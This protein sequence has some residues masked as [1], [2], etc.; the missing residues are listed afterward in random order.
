MF[1]QGLL[2]VHDSYCSLFPGKIFFKRKLLFLKKKIRERHWVRKEKTTVNATSSELVRGAR[3]AGSKTQVVQAAQE[4]GGGW[5]GIPGSLSEQGR[6]GLPCCHTRLLLMRA[7]PHA[8]VLG[9]ITFS[10]FDKL[11]LL[12]CYREGRSCFVFVFLKM[13]I[14]AKEIRLRQKGCLQIC[15]WE[16]LPC[17]CRS[18]GL[19]LCPDAFYTTV[20]RFF[21]INYLALGVHQVIC[22]L[23]TL[24]VLCRSGCACIGDSLA[25]ITL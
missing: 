11:R 7:A 12:G 5:K 25:L 6:P 15:S 14:F 22:R 3:Q 16:A 17:S 13:I 10:L 9:Q 19:Q 24:F 4:Q 20:K 2:Q 1:F 18:S 23:S 8:S 21:V